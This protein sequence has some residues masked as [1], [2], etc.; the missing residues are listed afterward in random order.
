[1]EKATECKYSAEIPHEG[2]FSSDISKT[3]VLNLLLLFR[4]EYI[5]LLLQFPPDLSRKPGK[6]TLKLRSPDLRL[7]SISVL[8]LVA[9][10]QISIFPV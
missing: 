7:V 9:I 6:V 5:K 1:M 8:L 2:L 4:Y 3:L 10:Q